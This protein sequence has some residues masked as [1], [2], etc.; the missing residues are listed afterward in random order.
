M[1][2]RRNPDA[3][4]LW[5]FASPL[6]FLVALCGVL[7]VGMLLLTG[8]EASVTA[9]RGGHL[10]WPAL[11][12]VFADPDYTV[13]VTIATA[14]L[15]SIPILLMIWRDFQRKLRRAR[16]LT[17]VPEEERPT[18]P[19]LLRERLTRDRWLGHGQRTQRASRMIGVAAALFALLL[20]GGCVATFAY[21]AQ[22]PRCGAQ[23]CPPPYPTGPMGMAAMMLVFWLTWLAPLIWRRRVEAQCGIVLHYR[24]ET[25]I[26][27]F[28][29]VR[30]PGVTAEAATTAL[31]RFI[32]P[33]ADNEVLAA[34]WLAAFV[35]AWAPMFIVLLG[36]LALARWLS[37]QW[38]PR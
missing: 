19:A 26:G 29:Y 6:R 12:W 7:A 21:I 37:D 14:G 27:P 30:R 33:R 9:S 25:N 20:L 15:V 34:R 8:W 22:F 4:L 18:P 28:D 36:G 10:P 32:S 16:D 1:R 3:L 5:L 35:F 24:S 11:Q 23:G 13:L 2:F 31:T 38:M 17:E